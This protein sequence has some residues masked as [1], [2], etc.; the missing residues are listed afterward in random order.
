MT[1]LTEAGNCGSSSTETIC[2]SALCILA[3]FIAR[4]SARAA[5]SEPSLA[6][7][8][9]LNIGCLLR[10]VDLG[11]HRLERWHETFLRNERW[12][13]GAANHGRNQ[14]RVLLLVDD[15]VGQAE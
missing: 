11:L 8:I 6:M 13:H 5:P 9:F 4:D 2:K 15:L 1:S 7:M 3:S 10:F 14:D 12:N